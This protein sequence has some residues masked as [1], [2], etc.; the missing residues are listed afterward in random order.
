LPDVVNCSGRDVGRIE[1]CPNDDRPS[2]IDS[3]IVAVR[4][5]SERLLDGQ[6][7]VESVGGKQLGNW[8][9]RFAVA[10]HR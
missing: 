10:G 8:F 3:E 9:D 4:I 5:L 6:A 2:W 1:E 7:L